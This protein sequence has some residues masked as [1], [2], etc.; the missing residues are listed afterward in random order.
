MKDYINEWLTLGTTRQKELPV[1]TLKAVTTELKKFNINYKSFITRNL[2]Y[3]LESWSQTSYSRG[4]ISYVPKIVTA[5][6]NETIIV[7]SHYKKV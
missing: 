5:G 4:L 6:F 3:F 1:T 2:R 7:E